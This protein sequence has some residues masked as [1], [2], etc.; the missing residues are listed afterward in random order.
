M[1]LKLKEIE[2]KTQFTINVSDRSLIFAASQLDKVKKGDMRI[3]LEFLKNLVNE[4]F[5]KTESEAPGAE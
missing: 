1:K 2:K 3:V 4:V 5:P